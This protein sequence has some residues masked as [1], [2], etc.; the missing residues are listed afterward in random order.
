MLIKVTDLAKVYESNRGLAAANFEIRR[1]ESVAIIGHN[2]A[3]KSTLLKMLAGWIVADHGDAT[4]NNVSLKDRVNLV[5]EIGFVPEIPNLFD[6][7]SLEYNL[8]FY[9]R[10]FHLSMSRVEDVMRDFE[11]IS[12]R[13]K[14]VQTLSKGMRQRV[15]F[16]RSMLTDPAVLLLDEP[17]SGLDF[18]MTKDIYRTLKRVHDRGRTILFTSHR[19]EEVKLL[20]TRI[21]GLDRGKIVFDGAPEHYFKSKAHEELYS[22]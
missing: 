16:G 21:I 11:L 13:S 19:P 15:S 1:G 2:G 3:G 5:R 18:D 14:S 10:L 12:F 20:A 17:T 4:I 6:Q 9:A 22:L 7:F 8:R